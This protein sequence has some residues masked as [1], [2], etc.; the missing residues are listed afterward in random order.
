MFKSF[1]GRGNKTHAYTH[2][3][4]DGHRVFLNLETKKFYCLPDNYEVSDHVAAD[5]DYDAD[6]DH[7]IADLDHNVDTDP[8]HIH[9][10]PI[11]LMRICITVYVDLHL[12]DIQAD[13]DYDEA[14]PNR[15]DSEP[16]P[17][18]F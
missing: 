13:L 17:K 8:Y 1:Q 18:I 11:V 12:V 9:A 15:V 3:V 2:S 5:L 14:D 7:L 16:D 4:S 10:D 6:Q